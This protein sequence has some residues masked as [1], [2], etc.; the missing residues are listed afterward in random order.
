MLA[1]LGMKKLNL[2]GGEPFYHPSYLGEICKYAKEVLGLESVSI[3]S[4][5]SLIKR[6]FFSGY[7][8]YLDILAIS[9][10]SFDEDT[11]V[12]I[13]RGKLRLFWRISL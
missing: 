7:G 11:N 4:N 8:K 9:V 12:K 2:S 1:D 13:G 10:D 3:V 6:T 5:G